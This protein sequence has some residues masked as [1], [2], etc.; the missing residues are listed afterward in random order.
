MRLAS[1][2]A[3]LG[4]GVTVKQDPLETSVM[5]GVIATWM[6]ILTCFFFPEDT[7]A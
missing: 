3:D 2:S 6:E 7:R 4:A 5:K 1:F